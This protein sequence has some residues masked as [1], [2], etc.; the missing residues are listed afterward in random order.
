MLGTA[1]QLS[2]LAPQFAAAIPWKVSATRGDSGV[3]Q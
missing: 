2:W 3:Y 1:L